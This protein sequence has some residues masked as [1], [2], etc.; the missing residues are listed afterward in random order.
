MKKNYKNIYNCRICDQKSLEK[1]FSLSKIPIPEIYETHKQKA[2]KKQRIPLTIVRCKECKHVQIREII[3][4][5][6]LWK[7]YTYF[8]GQTKAIDDHFKHLSK[9]II[10]DFKLTKK[11]LVVDIGSNDGSFLKK[12]KNKTKVL[13]IDP[14]RSV[15]KYAIRKNKIKTLIGYFD[16]ETSKKINN[17]FGKAKVV[18][19]FNVFAHTPSMISFVKNLRKILDHDGVFIFEA[20]YLKDI[21]QSN[22]LGTFFHEHISHHSIYSLK[23]LF[24][25][26]NL[27]LIKVENINVQKGSILGF[28]THKYNN[29]I[30][31][32]SVENF[33]D[34]EKNLKINSK[35]R[36]NIFKKKINTNKNKALSYIKKYKKIF[37]FGAARSGPTLLRNFQIEN[38]IKFLLDDHP[39]KINKFTPVSAIKIIRTS[40]LVKLMPD[41]TVILAYLH[42]KK[43]IKKNLDYLKK[44]GTFMILYPEPKLITKKNYL[45]II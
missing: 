39:M 31:D 6:D 17:N 30:L 4:Q 25:S 45:E 27:R 26:F 1:I 32:K 7:N 10:K 21:L 23:K 15:A 40:N 24:D 11:D 5:S 14:A 42:S 18:L 28:V 12:F 37:G 9:R 16:K 41:L 38:H 44:G 43:I 20:Q 3:D 29:F 22:I 8:S 36:L 35:H 33:I 34:N 13:G 19:A 2:K